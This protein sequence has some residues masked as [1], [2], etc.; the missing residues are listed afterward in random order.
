[1]QKRVWVPV[2]I[3][4]L[5]ALFLLNVFWTPRFFEYFPPPYDRPRFEEFTREQLQDISNMLALNVK[6][7][8]II[9]FVNTALLLYLLIL[10]I[11]V[12]RAT[13]SNFSLSLIL[14]SFT[15]ILYT[16]TNNPVL[17]WMTGFQQRSITQVFNFVPDVF[18]TV[19]S[20]I[21]IY[22]SRQ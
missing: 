3:L 17:I 10:H 22:L 19:A 11:D 8:L 16:I 4:G 15:L 2:M 1:M 7:R 5:L 18:T 21:L 12:Y 14:F 6:V 9:G 13:K 20:I